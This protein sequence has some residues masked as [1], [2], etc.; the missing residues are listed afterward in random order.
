MASRP[1]RDPLAITIP[2]AVL[3]SAFALGLVRCKAPV[4]VTVWQDRAIKQP[5]ALSRVSKSK[6]NET[7]NVKQ[8]CIFFFFHFSQRMAATGARERNIGGAQ[9]TTNARQWAEIT[10]MSV[11]NQAAYFLRKFL[12]KF[13]G[14]FDGN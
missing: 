10:S 5:S 8:L 2:P 14:K 11:E 12:L 7:V 3:A 13:A 1:L 6:N 4:N 9:S